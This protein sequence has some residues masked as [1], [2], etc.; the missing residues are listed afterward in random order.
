MK[1]SEIENLVFSMNFLGY[2]KSDVKDCLKEI[3]QYV[4]RLEEKV[5]ELQMERD[6]LKSE[7]HRNEANNENF[8]VIIKSAQEFKNR[9]ESEATE[10]AKSIVEKAK[11]DYEFIL[12]SIKIE[13]S[14][15][16]FL[17]REFENFK[18]SLFDKLSNIVKTIEIKEKNLKINDSNNKIEF[19]DFDGI[20][21]LDRRDE[22]VVATPLD[23]QGE[24]AVFVSRVRRDCTSKKGLMF[25][26]VADNL[27]KGAA[28]NSVQI[29][30]LLI[31]IDP[32]LRS[33]KY[34]A[35]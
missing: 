17:K 23:A 24:D 35:K 31:D 1:G 11:K 13:S 6:K 30:E 16:S 34:K 3:S 4:M 19:D 27:R 9:I 12:K 25:W 8:K 32:K 2:K 7:I 5:R 15:L 14:K 20:L 21:T 29:A 18:N 26:A 33:F 22:N 28:L 10:K